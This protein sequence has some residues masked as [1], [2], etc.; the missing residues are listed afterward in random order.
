VLINKNYHVNI[1]LKQLGCRLCFVLRVAIVLRKV[2]FEAKF[3]QWIVSG[4]N[5]E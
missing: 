5:Y 3:P 2:W 1:F 4:F